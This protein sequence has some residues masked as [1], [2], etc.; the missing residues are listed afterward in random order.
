MYSVQSSPSYRWR[1]CRIYHS[2]IHGGRAGGHSSQGIRLSVEPRRP[3]RV[4]GW[5][6]VTWLCAGRRLSLNFGD[7]ICYQ[8]PTRPT[9]I[10]LKGRLCVCVCAP[11]W[12]LEILGYGPQRLIFT[13]CRV[14]IGQNCRL[15]MK[16]CGC[17][18]E[19]GPE[20]RQNKE[21]LN[22]AAPFRRLETKYPLERNIVFATPPPQI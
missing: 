9:N 18:V 3:R 2:M 6:G 12:Y 1:T 19:S 22:P 10:P 8:S 17:Y 21:V 16:T 13:K 4:Q 5:R 14:E 20:R 15:N 7:G 11:I